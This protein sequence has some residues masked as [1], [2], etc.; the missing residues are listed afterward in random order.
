MTVMN[1]ILDSFAFTE[2]KLWG[3]M[4]VGSCL[5]LLSLTSGKK[6]DKKWPKMT[7]LGRQSHFSIEGKTHTHKTKI[8]K[9]KQNTH[10]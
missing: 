9:P 2:Y 8:N 5:D 7:I 3:L 10:T 1:L 4:H 6:K